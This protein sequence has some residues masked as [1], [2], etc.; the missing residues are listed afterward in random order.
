MAIQRYGLV[1]LA[2][3]IASFGLGCRSAMS[4]PSGLDLFVTISWLGIGVA[5]TA[6]GVRRRSFRMKLTSPLP[7]EI[8]IEEPG[9]NPQAF[10]W[11]DLSVFEPSILATLY[12][13]AL[14]MGSL[15]GLATI[16]WTLAGNAGQPDMDPWKALRGILIAGWSLAFSGSIL[17]ERTQWVEIRFPGRRGATF[18]SYRA[19]ER[20]GGR[21]GLKASKKV[22]GMS[23]DL[24]LLEKI[25][26]PLRQNKTQ[27]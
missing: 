18:F 10:K 5:C 19:L 23:L 4:S 8:S 12:F 2:T 26:E 15:G 13:L 6:Y 9:K 1:P 24:Y 27:R 22:A 7:G 25:I 17:A 21:D 20:I 16:L 14:F 3:G 11:S